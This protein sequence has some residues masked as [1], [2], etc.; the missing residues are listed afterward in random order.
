MGVVYAPCHCVTVIGSFRFEAE[1]GAVILQWAELAGRPAVVANW[2]DVGRT[3]I[4][5]CVDYEEPL[6]GGVEP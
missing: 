6:D 2:V 1:R 4:V 3:G 5:G